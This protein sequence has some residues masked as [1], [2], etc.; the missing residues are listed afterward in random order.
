[1]SE[2]CGQQNGEC[3]LTRVRVGWGVNLGVDW[4]GPGQGGPG[5]S[6]RSAA[7]RLSP[8]YLTCS[9]LSPDDL[10]PPSHYSLL[11]ASPLF[12]IYFKLAVSSCDLDH[13]TQF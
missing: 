9:W 8:E 5:E 10:P 6:G 3:A 2:P 4:A 7:S 1:M 12:F 11:H 13:L